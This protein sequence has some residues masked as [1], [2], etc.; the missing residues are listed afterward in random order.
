MAATSASVPGSSGAFREPPTAAPASPLV[1]DLAAAAGAERGV[2]DLL[3]ARGP[4][5]TLRAW[6][7]RR[8]GVAE[9]LTRSALLARLGEDFAAIDSALARQLDAILHDAQF[10]QLE[11]SWRGLAWLVGQASDANDTADGRSRIEVRILGVTKRELARD[12][13]DAVEFDRSAIWRK[14]YEE[15]F[16]TAGGKPYGLLV[17]DYQFNHRPDDVSLLTGL[18]EVSAA[19]FAPLL[20]NPAPELLGLDSFQRLDTLPVPDTYQSSPDFVKWRA[21]RDRDESRFIGLPLPRVLGRLPYDGWIGRPHGA[22]APERSWA[23]RGFRY[24]EEADRAD[25][26]G[27]LWSGAVWPLAGVVIQE[28]GRSGWFADIRGG[29]RGLEGGGLVQG[30]PVDGYTGLDQDDASRGPVEVFVTE[31]V[32]MDLDHAGLIPLCS[33]GPDGR[34]V[35]HSNASLHATVRYDSAIATANARISSQLQYVLCVSRFAHYLKVIARDKVGS[36]TEAPAFERYLSEWVNQ[37]VT[38]DDH[39][40]A[41]TRA[42][43]PLRGAQVEVR[44]EPGTAGAYRVIMRLQPHFQLDRL[45]ATLKLVTQV[46]R[47]DKR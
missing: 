21:L 11:S 23:Q 8:V 37:Y 26:S 36:F 44:E 19:A 32:Q 12:R 30:L 46:R 9:R 43:M 22:A 16:G 47:G 35:F 39:A 4:S 20:V 14:V 6:A 10:Q 5:E 41:E 25:G 40:S 7:A 13:S 17:A 34:A 28:F 27:R 45:D 33:S 42:R 29:S 2:G 18:A 1:R 31:P 38:P 24:R 15:E 3:A